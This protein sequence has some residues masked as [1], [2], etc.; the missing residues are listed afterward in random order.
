MTAGSLPLVSEDGRIHAT[1]RQAPPL[2]ERLAD[3]R[4]V[5]AVGTLAWVV[6]TVVI[7]L[8]G[9]RWDSLLPTCYAG[10]VIGGLG[11]LIFMIQRRA[12]RL[13]RRGAQK[14]IS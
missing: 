9:S 11:Y 1:D 6:T 7:L 10:I 14:G 2:P 13:G 4:P 12:V 3:P 5:V 8:T